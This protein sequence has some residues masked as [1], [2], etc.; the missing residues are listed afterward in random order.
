MIYGGEDKD[1]EALQQ[2]IWM[3]E[4]LCPSDEFYLFLQVEISESTEKNPMRHF[5][6]WYG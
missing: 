5:L 6:S 1:N 2:L 4:T 3:I